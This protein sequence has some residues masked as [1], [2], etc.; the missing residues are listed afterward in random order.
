LLTNYQEEDM[1]L[2]LTYQEAFPVY[3]LDS[4]TTHVELV[5]SVTPSML[6][7]PANTTMEATV[8]LHTSAYVP[9]LYRSKVTVIAKSFI[10][11]ITQAMVRREVSFFFTV[12]KA[13]SS[14]SSHDIHQPACAPL[15]MCAG[16]EDCPLGPQEGCEDQSWVARFLVSDMGSGL[17]YPSSKWPSEAIINKRGFILGSTEEH[18]VGVSTSCCYPGVRLEVRDLAGN[19]R[20]CEVGEVMAAGERLRYELGILFALSL[21]CLRQCD[22]TRI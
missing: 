8:L 3:N 6:V 21:W 18:T 17:D 16:A 19:T 15:T 2:I 20:L 1:S 14:L 11:N 4:F 5:S 9:Q 22:E 7:V 10:T 12:L 13:G